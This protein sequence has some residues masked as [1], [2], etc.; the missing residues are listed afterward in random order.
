MDTNEIT[1]YLKIL[2]NAVSGTAEHT[3]IQQTEE[4]PALLF[5]VASPFDEKGEI[6]CRIMLLPDD[7]GCVTVEMMM[8]LFG[9]I[10]SDMFSDLD[11]LLNAV[12]ERIMTGS[13]RLFDDQGMILFVQ[14]LMLDGS[15]NE[16][17]AVT[18]IG[19]TLSAMEYTV[20]DTAGVMISYLGGNTLESI[21]DELDKGEE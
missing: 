21:M 1:E 11:I 15:V 6:G 3:E 8:F 9:N 19:K 4:G 20:Y 12:N 18:L 13:Y 17:T 16:K 5:T 14:S 7:S 10:K 2:K